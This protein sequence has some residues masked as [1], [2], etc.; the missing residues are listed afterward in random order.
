MIRLS[1]IRTTAIPTRFRG[2]QRITRERELMT[3]LRDHLATPGSEFKFLKNSLWSPSKPRLKA[4][5]HDKCGYCEAFATAVAHCDVEHIRPKSV[6]WWLALC[7]DNYVLACQIC[8]QSH[9][10]DQ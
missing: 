5:A 1:R 4:E 6:Y 3:A 2:T 8:N 9:P 7:Y 10:G